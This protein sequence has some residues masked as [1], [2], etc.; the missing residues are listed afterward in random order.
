MANT[1]RQITFAAE[2]AGAGT[3][4]VIYTVPDNTTTIVLG[5]ML[6]NLHSSAV[7]T[8]IE[9]VSTTATG[10]NTGATQTN[11]TA[12]LVNDLSIPI[13]GTLELLNGGKL[14]LQTG[15][16]LR[17]DCS[18]ADKLSGALSIMEIT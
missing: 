1:F 17:I 5:L 2:P 14:V 8:E 6:S 4:F 3:P 7:T 12:F 13:A 15:D 18:V 11:T 10:V 16:I 9:L